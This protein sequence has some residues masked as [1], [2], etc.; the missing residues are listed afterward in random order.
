MLAR[1]LGRLDVLSEE[2]TVEVRHAVPEERGIFSIPFR[3]WSV[4]IC[5]SVNTQVG[6]H[7]HAL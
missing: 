7:A 6:E 5:K 2:R 1:Q 3:E 4:L